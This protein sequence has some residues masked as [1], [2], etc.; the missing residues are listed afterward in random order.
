M[1]IALV[2]SVEYHGAVS[3]GGTTGTLTTTG[4]TLLIVGV[5]AAYGG[6]PGATVSDSKSNTWNALTTHRYDNGGAYGT[7]SR[8]YYAQNPTV[9]TGH[10]FTVAG[11]EIY[12]AIFVQAFSGTA[13]TS[14]YDGQENGQTATAVTTLATGSVMPSLN[15]C[16]CV[17]VICH[18][19]TANVTIDGGFTISNT[20]IQTGVPGTPYGGSMAYLI[21]TV[22]TAANPSYSWTTSSEAATSIA[23]FRDPGRV[24]KNTR[25]TGLGMQHGV[26]FRIAPW[27]QL[28]A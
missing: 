24:T 10:T 22:A 2:T 14:V 5:A 8:L 20:Y 13:L 6:L 3:T 9:G 1:A 17:V 4:A 26:G 23:V 15:S 7:A 18:G 19:A 11:T 25:S 27:R 28:A 16:V 21:Q 12:P